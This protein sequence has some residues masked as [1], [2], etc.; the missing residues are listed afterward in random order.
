VHPVDTTAFRRLIADLAR[1]GA[2]EVCDRERYRHRL[3]I[4][5]EPLDSVAVVGRKR[6]HA[7]RFHRVTSR[8]RR[9]PDRR[10]NAPIRL[11]TSA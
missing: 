6:R 8:D 9:G 7:G 1:S 5:R 3:S 4:H 11:Q 2:L 10:A